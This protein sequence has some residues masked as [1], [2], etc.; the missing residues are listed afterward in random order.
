VKYAGWT[1]LN[2]A[3]SCPGTGCFSHFVVQADGVTPVFPYQATGSYPNGGNGGPQVLDVPAT[4]IDY[5]NIGDNQPHTLVVEAVDQLGP[6]PRDNLYDG[7][8]YQPNIPFV[9][10]LPPG[11]ML[12]SN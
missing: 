2:P 7:S 10:P 9:S 8:D 5:N 6:A 1:H 11:A 3:P 4:Q 12:G